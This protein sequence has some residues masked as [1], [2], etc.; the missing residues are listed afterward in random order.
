MLLFSFQ[1]LKFN[2]F[3]IKIISSSFHLLETKKLSKNE[4]LRLA[5]KYIRLLSNVLEWQKQ[6]ENV[7]QTAQKPPVIRRLASRHNQ[8]S[9]TTETNDNPQHFTIDPHDLTVLIDRHNSSHV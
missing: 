2:W 3:E 7:A 8:I 5:I 6:Q 4:I 1:Y 9:T